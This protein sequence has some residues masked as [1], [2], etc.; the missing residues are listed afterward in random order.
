MNVSRVW[1][2]SCVDGGYRSVFL[3]ACGGFGEIPCGVN[4]RFTAGGTALIHTGFVTR[5]SAVSAIAKRLPNRSSAGKPLI[6]TCVL[7]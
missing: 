1:R 2:R 4:P 5:L 3:F 6:D 7:F